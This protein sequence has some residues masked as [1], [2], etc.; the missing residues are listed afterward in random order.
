MPRIPAAVRAEYTAALAD[1][2]KVD[3]ADSQKLIDAAKSADTW[4]SSDGTEGLKTLLTEHRDRFESAA[5][6]TI[7]R[8]LGI[9]VPKP[10]ANPMELRADRKV[11]TTTYWPYSD[12]SRDGTGDPEKNLWADGGCLEK[13]D[14]LLEKR[15]KPTGAKSHEKRSAVGWIN[16][17]AN[18]YYLPGGELRESDAERT[19]GLDLN[20]N[21]KVDEDF[22]ND[23]SSFGSNG[24]TDGSIDVGWWGSCD[25]VALAGQLFGEP[26]WPVNLDGVRFTPQDIKGLLTVI[27]TSQAGRTE[28]VGYRYDGAPD[29]VR[30]R[31]GSQLL[32]TIE[33]YE[34][35]DF[36]TGS[37]HR[38]GDLVTRTG[39]EKDIELTT[40]TGE[41]V[42]VPASQV[43]S[44]TRESTMDPA[45]AVFHETVQ[46]W[47]ADKRP[48][49]MDH[50]AGDHVWND[51]YDGAT[52]SKTYDVPEGLD[53]ATLNGANG[54][55]S[56]GELTFYATELLKGDDAV[57]LYYYWIEED[58][59]E[60]VNS[61]WLDDDSDENPDFMW[62]PTVADAA[63][64]GPNPRN[65][66]VLPELVKELYEES[67]TVPRG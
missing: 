42:D 17:E 65:P 14:A 32:G 6:D 18:G 16:G 12:F 51:N 49:A 9:D 3:A 29:V 67:L 61:G 57:K 11:W 36:R 24:R 15:G 20:H 56:G 5:A 62:R 50:D 40:S 41:R 10:P 7:A 1:D 30:E 48:F 58:G 45:P 43:A 60:A 38:N 55:Y 28:F 53:V 35:A 63:F 37:F 34:I 19:T 33:N 4:W 27:A 59:G 46:K 2:Q 31:D 8:F 44:V 39:V 64:S 22:L 54:Q 25:K 66:Y 26:E 21:G 52:I 13:F 23:N 47:L